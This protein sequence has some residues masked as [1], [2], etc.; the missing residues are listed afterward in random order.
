MSA[1]EKAAREQF[2]KRGLKWAAGCALTCTIPGSL[3]MENMTTGMIAWVI[4]IGAV[5]TAY[6]F[7]KTGLG[8]GEKSEQPPTAPPTHP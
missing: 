8:F 4:W 2:L 3:W 7:L 5:L 6:Q 1:V